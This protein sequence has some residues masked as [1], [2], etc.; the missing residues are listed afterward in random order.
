MCPSI[1]LFPQFGWQPESDNGVPPCG[2]PPGP[3]SGITFI[4]KLTHFGITK[5][6][7]TFVRNKAGTCFQ[8]ADSIHQVCPPQWQAIEHHG[9]VRL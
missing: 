6:L 8:L 3:L 7:P 9:Q 1:E 2:G 5:T 4:D